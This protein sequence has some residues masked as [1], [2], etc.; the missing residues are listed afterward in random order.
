[1]SPGTRKTRAEH[2]F[3]TYGILLG[4]Q[5]GLLR[6]KCP[7][8]GIECGCD[9]PKGKRKAALGAT[10][11]TLAVNAPFEYPE[12][13]SSRRVRLLR[14]ADVFS[15]GEW[16]RA[17]AVAFTFV[18]ATVQRRLGW[19]ARTGRHNSAPIEANGHHYK[20]HKRAHESTFQVISITLSNLIYWNNGEG[21]RIP[22]RV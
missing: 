9:S 18:G 4:R 1:V 19:A 16:L 6:R 2:P 13:S 14:A 5:Q 7:C 12:W 17:A 15:R 21:R 11:P 8:R 10:A 3:G 20:E 22:R